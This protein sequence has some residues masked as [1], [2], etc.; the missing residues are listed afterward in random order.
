MEDDTG[1]IEKISTLRTSN[2]RR[3]P[4]KLNYNS[5]FITQLDEIIQKHPPIVDSGPAGLSTE[6][7]QQQ[8]EQIPV[9]GSVNL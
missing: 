6:S 3:E 2:F 9:S 8:L 1:R 4:S 5:S 7:T